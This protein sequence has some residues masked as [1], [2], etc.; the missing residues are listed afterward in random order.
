MHGE[1]ER[2]KKSGLAVVLVTMMASVLAL[3][4]SGC[5]L[6]SPEELYTLPWPSTE[7][8]SLQDCLN[9]L[10][11]KG[12]EYSPPIS[13]SYTQAVQLRD[14][15]DDGVDE[16]V[17]FLRDSSGKERPLKICILR[18]NG[19]EGYELACMIEGDGDVVNSVVY[20]QLNSTRTEE[21]VVG[22][23]ISST[24]YALSA[25]SIENGNVTELMTAPSYT[26]Y[27]VNDL[28][29]D[30]QEEIVSLQF[31][32]TEEGGNTA[33]Y[34]DWAEDTMMSINTVAL[35]AAADSLESVQYNYLVG[36]YPALYVSSYLRDNSS[37]LITDVLSVVG[38]DLTN[39][40]ASSDTGNSGT[41]HL[42]LTEPRDINSDNV[43]ELPMP[44]PLRSNSNV[45]NSETAYVI[46]WVQFTVEGTSQ[47]V[48]YT[49]H[50]TAD[51]WYLSLP[52]S[53]FTGRQDGYMNGLIL[54]R[55]DT[56][57][58]ATVE[59]SITFYHQ[60]S[61][62]DQPKAFLTIYKSTGTN[63]ESRAVMGE[64][65]LLTQDEEATYSA[66]FLDSGWYC[67]LSRSTLAE[68][69]KLILTD[70]SAD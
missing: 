38:G 20:C 36:S 4:L 23:R 40:T 63:R 1:V 33:T 58:G 34:Y 3:L 2:V 6:S 19:G 14:L 61:L 32:S 30:N 5:G 57:V 52:E 62:T 60:E 66:E 25:Y 22:W 11:D 8:E 69:F 55:S 65:F 16:A 59:R 56:N 21:I 43:L 41:V 39:I 48:G 70:W 51:G 26:R 15:D 24:V 54:S 68:R 35:S 12:Y 46:N 27:V 13:G 44:I 17:A 64:R 45:E 50:N 42:N 10:L 47:T 29:Q 67:G 53:W 28:D 9:Q 49:Y 37:S 7:Y 18:S 31:G